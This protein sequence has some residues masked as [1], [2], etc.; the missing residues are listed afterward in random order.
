MAVLFI[1]MSHS[2]VNGCERDRGRSRAMLT[3]GGM[4]LGIRN[5]TPCSPSAS[6]ALIVSRS[7]F[8]EWPQVLVYS[9]NAGVHR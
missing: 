1:R 6:S 9:A 8:K 5:S 4:S 7:L 3:A 2:R